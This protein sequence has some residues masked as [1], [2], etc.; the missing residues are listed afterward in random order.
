MTEA[1]PDRSTAT[2]SSTLPT[3]SMLALPGRC[4]WRFLFQIQGARLCKPMYHPPIRWW[5]NWLECLDASQREDFEERAGI[6]Q[7]DGQLPRSHAEC[8]AMLDLLRRHPSLLT[9]VIVLQIEL[10][11]GT[12][13][14]L[15]T[16]LH[17]R[18]ALRRGCGRQGNRRGQPDRSRRGAIRRDRCADDLGLTAG[19]FVLRPM[20][21]LI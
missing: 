5:P 9:G 2:P 19:R 17:L 15:T 13:W 4:W 6:M 3:P 16:D 11:G 7:F 21:H 12:E 8:R 18:P 1:N 10:D 14:L 20:A